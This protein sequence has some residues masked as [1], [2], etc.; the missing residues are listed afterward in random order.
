MIA[1]T[2]RKLHFEKGGPC[3][4]RPAPRVQLLLACA[5][6]EFEK[7]RLVLRLLGPEANG[8]GSALLSAG[9]LA[10]TAADQAARPAAIIGTW[11]DS[12]KAREIDFLGI[13]YE[14][15]FSPASGT[16]EVRWTARPKLFPKLPVF[17]D[18]P[19]VLL[20][21]PIAYWVPVTKPEVIDRLKLHGVK[22][23]TLTTPRTVSVEMYRLVNPQPEPGGNGQPFE[24]RHLFQ[25]GVKAETHTGTFPAGSVR[26]PTDQ[27]LGELVVAMLEPES[28]DSLFTWGFFPE[29]LQRTEYIEGY[30]VAPM[31][32][33]M[34]ADD[35]SLKTAFEAR[36]AA[37]PKFATDSFAR[38]QWFYD[39][40]PFR[41]SRYLLYPVAIE[42]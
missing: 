12:G 34:L 15:Y 8:P 7:K 18:K 4:R 2:G 29:I 28:T 27:S 35:P 11:L 41:D 14:T 19:G 39:H 31:A 9:L 22:F 24:G 33:R 42:R 20:K 6:V 13:D 23:E 38:L 5:G 30:V 25:T 10:A 16:H 37:D 26:V 17:G 40:S 3:L 21:R 1:L 32:E 36:L